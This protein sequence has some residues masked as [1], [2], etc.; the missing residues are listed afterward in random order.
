MSISLG[1][2]FLSI[3]ASWTEF[4]VTTTPGNM[5]TA[6]DHASQSK[7]HHHW[8]HHKYPPCNYEQPFLDVWDRLLNT[9]K[10]D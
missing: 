3:R 1:I 7:T 10:W 4:I 8:L 2:S 9:R 5:K 6:W